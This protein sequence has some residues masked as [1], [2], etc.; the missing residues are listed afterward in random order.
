MRDA[1][2][3]VDNFVEKRVWRRREP[4]GAEACRLLGM[5]AGKKVPS[6]FNGLAHKDRPARKNFN[7]EDGRCRQRLFCE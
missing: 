2:D 1:N 5:G 4:H 3:A 7:P 6:K